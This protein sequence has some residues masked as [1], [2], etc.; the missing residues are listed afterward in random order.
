MNYQK[1]LQMQQQLDMHIMKKQK[2]QFV[3]LNDSVL[4]T[5]VELAEAANDEQSFKHWKVNREPKPTL[6]EEVSDFTHFLLSQ[7][8]RFKVTADDINQRGKIKY[9]DISEHFIQ[10]FH[11]LTMIAIYPNANKK[12]EYVLIAWSLFKGLLDHLNISE[13]QIE[14]AY[15]KKNEINYQ[16]QASNY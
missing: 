12:R 9:K 16:R 2:L 7:S 1:L 6:L 4:A 3:M 11:V 14:Q 15:Y 13:E 8:N 5:I 10:T